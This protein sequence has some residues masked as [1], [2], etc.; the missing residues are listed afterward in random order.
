VLR[1]AV[2]SGR[3]TV[4]FPRP[5][6]PRGRSRFLRAP[7]SACA[8]RGVLLTASAPAEAPALQPALGHVQPRV[9]KQSGR[10]LQRGSAGRLTVDGAGRAHRRLS[11]VCRRADLASYE[12]REC[13]TR[14]APPA[15]PK[16]TKERRVLPPKTHLPFCGSVI[17][18]ASETRQRIELES[19]RVLERP[20]PSEHVLGRATTDL[21]SARAPAPPRARIRAQ[22]RRARPS[23]ACPRR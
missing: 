22:W 8:S 17:S 5:H 14:R 18:P 11:R 4:L 9:R 15:G 10:A 7:E 19:Q 6:S 2:A 1:G 3:N 20:F 21:R 12:V 13:G 16:K 23:W